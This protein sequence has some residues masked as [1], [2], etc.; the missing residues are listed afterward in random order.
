MTTPLPPTWA[1]EDLPVLA[2]AIEIYD[3]K[4]RVDGDDIAAKLDLPE[5]TVTRS[6]IRLESEYV[7]LKH[8]DAMGQRNVR[9]PLVTS[10]SGEARRAAGQWPDPDKITADIIAHLDEAADKAPE[11]KKR[12]IRE[13]LHGAA[14]EAAGLGGTAIVAALRAYVGM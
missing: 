2:A 3:E 4:G 14:G 13:F 11:D 8:Y 12:T 5:E 7:T 10:I 9:A 1:T 6:L